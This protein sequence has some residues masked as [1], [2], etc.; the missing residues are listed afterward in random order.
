MESIEEDAK[1]SWAER[2]ALT[3]PH[4]LH[5]WAA[6]GAIDLHSLGA[7]RIQRSDGCK[8][9]FADSNGFQAR[10]QQIMLD[11]VIGLLREQW[12][13]AH[14]RTVDEVPQCKEMVDGGLA[15]PEP[16]LARAAQATL[17]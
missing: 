9:A 7:A 2:A 1:K 12:A 8:H 3:H 10:P 16:T 13:L 4:L 6:C 5:C 15:W 11:R 14:A 17:L